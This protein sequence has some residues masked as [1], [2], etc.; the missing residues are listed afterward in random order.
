MPGFEN[1][2]RLGRMCWSGFDHAQYCKSR[3]QDSSKWEEGKIVGGLCFAGREIEA[4][5]VGSIME[6]ATEL[7]IG[8]CSQN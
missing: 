7:E 8:I 2:W 4:K 3:W 6:V 5:V 1:E